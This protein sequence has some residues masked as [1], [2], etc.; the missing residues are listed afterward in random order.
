MG[1]SVP[2]E[3]VLLPAGLTG[4]VW[5]PP[6]VKDEAAAAKGVQAAACVPEPQRKPAAAP[7][8]AQVRCRSL[9]LQ[10]Q[11]QNRT[12]GTYLAA[13]KRLP[14]ILLV[15]RPLDTP[16]AHQTGVLGLHPP[17]ACAGGP[18]FGGH[19][20][21]GARCRASCRAEAQGGAGAAGRGVR[22]AQRRGAC[23]RA[24]GQ[25][26]APP[27]PRANPGHALR[28]RLGRLGA[29]IHAGRRGR[30]RR[31]ASAAPRCAAP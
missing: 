3:T 12:F 14:N 2:S 19:G 25:A 30:G 8:P 7:A 15:S 29:E 5:R 31:R 18:C 22:L 28:R 4:W 17:V 6:T 27:P 16:H 10:G 23:R 26:Q 24:G 13:I 1:C 11:G 21:R 20:G 9:R